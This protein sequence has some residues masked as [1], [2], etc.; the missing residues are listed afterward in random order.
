M[1][2][3]DNPKGMIPTWLINWGAKVGQLEFSSHVSCCVWYVVWSSTVSTDHA[4]CLQGIPTV[5]S[6][7]GKIIDPQPRASDHSITIL[8]DN[9]IY[10]LSLIFCFTNKHFIYS[11]CGNHDI[12]YH[13]GYRVSHIV[14]S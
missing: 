10:C 5:S 9:T 6:G 4:G 14:P 8:E 7:A 13:V 2:Y 1:H 11:W 3:Y 12:I